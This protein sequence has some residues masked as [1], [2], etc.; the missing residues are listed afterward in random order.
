[1]TEAQVFELLGRKQ[2]AL[3]A[4]QSEYRQFVGIVQRVKAG[5]I[6]LDRLTFRGMDWILGPEIAKQEESESVSA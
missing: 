4:M 3:E 5:E 2:A 6:S 1:M